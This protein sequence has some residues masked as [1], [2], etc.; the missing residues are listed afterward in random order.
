MVGLEKGFLYRLPL[1]GLLLLSFY[2]A[3]LPL[4]SLII[5][6]VL[7]VILLFMRGKIWKRSEHVMEKYLPFTKKWPNWLQKLVMFLIFIVIYLIIKYIVYFILGL[8]GIDLTEI[9]LGSIDV[10]FSE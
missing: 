2:A 7:F 5:L 4:E 6:G 8:M 9:I 1:I 10:N 3:G